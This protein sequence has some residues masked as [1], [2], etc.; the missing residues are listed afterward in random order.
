MEAREEAHAQNPYRKD[1][2]LE[3]IATNLTYEEARGLEQ[4]AMLECHTLNPGNYMNNQIN[5]ISPFNPRLSYYM[6][7]GR[8]VAI[9][10]WENQI[11]NEILYWIGR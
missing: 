7:A 1:L 10:Y 9:R 8:N 5:G 6:D 4:I 3:V 11:S 2:R